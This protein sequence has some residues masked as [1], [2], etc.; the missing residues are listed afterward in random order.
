[1]NRPNSLKF[2]QVVTVLVEERRQRVLDLV[3]ERGFITLADLAQTVAVSES[4]LRRDLDYWHQQGMLRRTH[5]GAMYIGDAAT[6]PALEE[7]SGSQ[8]EEKKIIAH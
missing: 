1:M 6:L 4:T 7:R 3:G 2:K 8:L 5:G